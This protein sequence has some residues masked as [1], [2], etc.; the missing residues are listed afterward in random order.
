[1]KS[2]HNTCFLYEGTFHYD[3]KWMRLGRKEKEAPDPRSLYSLNKV[4]L[5]YI[6]WSEIERNK[7]KCTARNQH[8]IL[9]I[10][11]RKISLLYRRNNELEKWILRQVH[12]ICILWLL[13]TR[14]VDDWIARLFLYQ[15]ILLYVCI[16]L[17][18]E[19]KNENHKTRYNMIFWT[20][21]SMFATHNY[22]FNTLF[23][24]KKIFQR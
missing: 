7:R 13:T 1:M 21:Y 24:F 4:P 22:Y 14:I 19:D 18:Y 17:K 3:G 12:D 16:L 20:W 9:S 2:C 8:G 10:T 11:A 15:D 23:L 5:V 6:F